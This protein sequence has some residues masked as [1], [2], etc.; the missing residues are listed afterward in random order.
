MPANNVDEYL[1]SDS[2]PQELKE[3]QQW[4]NWGFEERDGKSTKVPLNPRT[5]GKA[6]SNNPNT[7]TDF[8][9]VLKAYKS[10]EN[11]RIAGVGFVFSKDDDYSGTDLDHCR[12]LKTG[13]I[14]SWAMGVIE[15]LNSYSEI[16]PSRTGIKI[17]TRG[18]LPVAG[19]GSKN[20]NIEM[21]H[22]KKFFTVTGWHL[23]GTPLTIE[24]RQEE[25]R[26]IYTKHFGHRKTSPINQAPPTP[27]NASDSEL[28]QKAKQASNGDKFQKLLKGDSSDYP[29]QS[30]A[31]FALCSML[32]F[33]T[34]RDPTRVDQ[35]FR[36]SGLMRPK[37][38]EKHFG[39]GT[40]YGQATV[41]KVIEQTTEAYSPISHSEIAGKAIV[42]KAVERTEDK[43]NL[44]SFPESIISGWAG[45]FTNLYSQYVESPKPFLFISF[46]CCLGSILSPKLALKSERPFQ[47]RLYVLLLGESAVERKSTALDL[48]VEFFREYFKGQLNLCFG[49]GSAEGLQLKISE[50]P[51]GNL[52]LLVDEFKSLLNKCKI[53]GSVLL[54]CL[55][56]LF[57]KNFYESRTKHSD[58]HV[59][60]G[61][62]SILAASTIATYE[63]VWSSVFID[64]GLPNRLFIVPSTS[65]R[66]YPVPLKIPDNIKRNLAEKIQTEVL[67][68]VDM[69][70]EV[71]L[72]KEAEKIFSD[73]YF[74]I[75]KEETIHTKRLDT[76]ALRFMPL[77]AVNEGKT[78]VDEAIVE[79]VITLMNWQKSV[80]EEFDPIDANSIIAIL[81]EKIRRRLKKSTHTTGELKHFIKVSKE[82]LWTFNMALNNLSTGIA[83]EIS[84]NPIT[85]KWELI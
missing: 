24:P 36:Q 18:I 32:A 52:L 51:N 22:R 85:K 28:I 13:T 47:P 43:K 21:Y 61:H 8:G 75:A 26:E 25:L 23:E 70:L 58:I 66:L 31:D 16:S 2:I 42:E 68:T 19:S 35:L 65:K 62:L 74:D 53:E 78:I 57:E 50:T 15:A 45:E 60:N 82:G 3:L 17:F 39:D 20:G 59:E 63:S 48:P 76:Y 37:W 83:K 34:G 72:T 73:W 71:E 27:V 69:H 44:N 81:E 79:K 77:F 14:E 56:T 12:N 30:E 11:D 38:D 80:R 41:Q 54:P 7:W 84:F 46:L 5:K 67:D 55:N 6:Q 64:I 49:V 9:T 10:C 4:V 29:S 40:T 1:N 33:W